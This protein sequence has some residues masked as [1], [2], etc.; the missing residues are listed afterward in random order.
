MSEIT[1]CRDLTGWRLKLLSGA[2]TEY[3]AE[4]IGKDE[5]GNVVIQFKLDSKEEASDGQAQVPA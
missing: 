3:W 1:E 4:C 5:H 2:A